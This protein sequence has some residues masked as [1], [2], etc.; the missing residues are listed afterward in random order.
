MC[1]IAGALIYDSNIFKPNKLYEAIDSSIDR[2]HDS[3]GIIKHNMSGWSDYKST[4]KFTQDNLN[5][6]ITDNVSDQTLIIHTSRAE[7]TTEWQIDK[8]ENNIPPFRNEQYAVAHNGIIS[9]DKE[10]A[11][12]F[13]INRSSSIDTS[14]LPDLFSKIGI[15]KGINEIDGGSA[16][17]IIESRENSLVLCRNFM[18][19]TLVWEPGA[20]FFAS[21]SRFF[22]NFDQPFSPFVIW[23]LPPYTCIKLSAKGFKYPIPW[24]EIPERDYV[25]DWMPYPNLIWR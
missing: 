9:N 13:N 12:K 4:T 25:N 1:G 20:V 19:L 23:E 10:L 14:I 11:L 3:Y 21:E 15:W 8:S 16:L 5:S 6:I 2:G 17:A 18:P 7:P 22:R 24:G